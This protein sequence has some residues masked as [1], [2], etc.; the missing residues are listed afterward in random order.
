VTPGDE[1]LART[2]SR[3]RDEPEELRNPTPLPLLILAVAMVSWGVWYYFANA[4]FPLAAGDR[5]TPIEELS[6]DQV[7]GAQVFAANCVACHQ[8]SGAGLSGVFPPLVDSRWVLGSSERLVQIMLHGIQG[9]IEVKGAVYNGVMPAF[10]RLSDAELAAV[11]THI[12]SAWG[13]AGTPI[14][15]E[16]IAAGRA[17]DP[18]RTE[19]WNGGEELAAVFGDD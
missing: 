8:A 16:E 1:R 14:G 18:E 6:L 11:T 12:R 3:E 10:A 9:P 17:R 13:N 7:D 4:G 15:V 2:Q 5:R 19:P